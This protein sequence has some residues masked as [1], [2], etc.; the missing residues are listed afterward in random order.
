M[1]NSLRKT[2]VN[3]PESDTE[4]NTASVTSSQSLHNEKHGKHSDFMRDAIIG[5]ADGLT[6]P[7]AL[8]AGLSA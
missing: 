8:T 7:F 1:F 4:S 2:P 3:L 6:V 5:F